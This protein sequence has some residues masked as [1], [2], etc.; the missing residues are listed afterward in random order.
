M[1]F[2]R[3]LLDALQITQDKVVIGVSASL[4]LGNPD[5]GSSTAGTPHF[6]ISAE[7][8]AQ[9]RLVLCAPRHS[10]LSQMYPLFKDD[11]GLGGNLLPKDILC[12]I[13][14]VLESWDG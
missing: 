9:P 10:R 8:N 14:Q 11:F 12:V 13:K 4:D 7:I 1:V 2:S 3:Q 6:V 5:V